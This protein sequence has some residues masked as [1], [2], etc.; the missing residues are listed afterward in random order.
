MEY[1]LERTLFKEEKEGDK[2]LTRTQELIG[3]INGIFSDSPYRI[4]DIKEKSLRRGDT[5]LTI[6]YESK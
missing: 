3:M 1:R 5:E 2:K 6:L 4:T